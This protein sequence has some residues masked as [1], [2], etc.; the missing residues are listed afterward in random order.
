MME[1][2]DHQ[3]LLVQA[4][5]VQLALRD[6]AGLTARLELL[7]DLLARLDW[8]LPSQDQQ[9]LWVLLDRLVL[10]RLVMSGRRVQLARAL[11]VL[12]GLALQV[13]GDLMV[14]LVP[15]ELKVLAQQV[16]LDR[17]E[18][19]VPQELKVLVHQEQ[20]VQLVHL[21]RLDQLSL[22]LQERWDLQEQ[23]VLLDR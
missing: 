4:L 21:V 8:I 1:L 12:R 19:L 5:L 15:Q 18:L 3:E 23:A 6:C 9:D 13:L 7:V 10:V 11:P 20:L 22:V 16:K 17:L 2:Q 14:L